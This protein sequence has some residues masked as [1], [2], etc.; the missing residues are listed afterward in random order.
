MN[1]QPNYPA[2]TMPDD[3]ERL[4][5]MIAHLSPLVVGFIG[6][7][8]LMMADLS[9]RPEGPSAFVKHHAKQSL[10]WCIALII[11]AMVT[12]GIGGMVMMVWQILA[13][14]AA[15]RGEWYVYPGLSSFVD[16]PPPSP[17]PAQF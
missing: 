10:I 16:A 15:N 17:P 6:P 8:I 13:G 12:C 2:T 7:L 14:M 1:A 4:W 11:V 3:K 5:G 9:G